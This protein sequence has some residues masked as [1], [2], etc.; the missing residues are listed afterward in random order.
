MKSH[1]T[2]ASSKSAGAHI[3]SV[4]A[5]SALEYL[6]AQGHDPAPL[7]RE[8]E[9]PDVVGPLPALPITVRTERK[10][11]RR[12]ERLLSDPFFGLRMVTSRP[13]GS[14][15]AF[16][17]ALRNA[18]NLQGALERLISYPERATPEGFVR[19]CFLLAE[20][21]EGAIFTFHAVG[22]PATLA[23]HRPKEEYLLGLVVGLVRQVV[24]EEWKP[25]AT[26]F[27]SPAPPDLGPL[28]Q[29]FGEIQYGRPEA[30]L[31][32]DRETLLAPF[33]AADNQLLEVLD[34]YVE[35][36][37]PCRP[38]ALTERVRQLLSERLHKGA[39]TI[40]EIASALRMS[41]R[42]FQRRLEASGT[43]YETVLTELRRHLAQLYLQDPGRSVAEVSYLLG[44]S[45]SRAFVRAFKGWTGVTPGGYRIRAG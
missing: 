13:P 28:P 25:L 35:Q 39:P 6:R 10:L 19:D 18:P 4:Y 24:D 1:A 12:I 26:G 11:T 40:D 9:L 23:W 8:L 31:Y 20:R 41:R 7:V 15:G 5:A 16:E 14:F 17:F 33:P 32:I 21:P 3:M 2:R 45:D 22:D 27:A 37:A 44:Y 30:S 36:L 43:T 29:V 34:R 42:T 38:S